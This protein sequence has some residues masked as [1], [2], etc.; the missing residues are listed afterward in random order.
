MPALT[1]QSSHLAAILSNNSFFSG[2]FFDK[3]EANNKAWYA[4]PAGYAGVSD[5]SVDRGFNS[6]SI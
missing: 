4:C 5:V 6:V 3:C 1:L 2:Y